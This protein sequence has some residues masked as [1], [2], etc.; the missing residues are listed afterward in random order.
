MERIEIDVSGSTVRK[1]EKPLDLEASL[2][3][4]FRGSNRQGQREWVRGEGKAVAA[5]APEGEAWRI[6]S[7]DVTS[8]GSLVSKRETFTDITA[9]LGLVAADPSLADRFKTAS[10]NDPHGGAAAAAGLKTL[11]PEKVELNPAFLDYGNDGD[12]DLFITVLTQVILLENRLVPDGRL[13]LRDAPTPLPQFSDA[14]AWSVAIGDVNKDGLPDVYVNTYIRPAGALPET[15]VD[16][17]NALPNLLYVNQGGGVFKEEARER[18]VADS[19][20]I[21]AAQFAGVDGDSDLDL[22]VA[23]DYGGGNSLYIN[24][25]KG[26][27]TDQAE[28]RGSWLAEESMG[29]SFADYD[30]DG[31][32]DL[33]VT[34]MSSTS[35]SRALSR[36]EGR[37]MTRPELLTRQFQGNALLENLRDGTFRDR[38]WD[39]GPFFSDWAGATAS[40]TSTTTAGRT[41]TA[42]TASSRTTS[43]TTC[44]AP[45]SP[46][47]SWP[48]S[49]R[50]VPRRSGCGWPDCPSAGFSGS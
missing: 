24:D 32:L 33:H 2:K 25:G 31:D 21:M 35:V 30:K 20:Y 22:Y 37:S 3:I 41:S 17:T 46:A 26:Y 28:K 10:A 6:S 43:P 47:S 13:T 23:N 11:L 48:C 18:G 9:A 39:A 42:P 45:T 14:N 5:M 49:P 16:D 29:V 19:R 27:F 44:A 4:S 36:F 15:T 8:L 1:L 7:F 34:N 38:R 50:T 12:S 40:S